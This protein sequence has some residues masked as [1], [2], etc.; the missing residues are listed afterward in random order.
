[1]TRK[2]N[3][4]RTV[5]TL[6]ALALCGLITGA[7]LYAGP[8]TPPVGPVAP[9]LKTL[10]EVEPRIAINATNT[11]GDGDSVFRITSPGSYYLT[12]NLSGTSGKMGIE[13]ASTNV[14]I[15]LSGFSVL[16]GPG[17]LDG[18]A[19][20]ASVGQVVIRNGMITGWGGDGL[21]LSTNSAPGSIVTM[22]TASANA[23]TGIS[24]SAGTMVTHCVAY[25]NTGSGFSLAA[26]SSIANCNA[27]LNSAA[28]LVASNGVNISAF[29]AYQN[30]TV[31]INAGSGSTVIGCTARFNGLDGILAAQATLI[32][33]CVSSSNGFTGD[34]AGIHI[35]GFDCRVEGNTCTFSDRGIDVDSSGNF[36]AR[37]ICSGNGTNWDVAA[38]NICLVV[39]GAPATAIIGNSGGVAPGS[40]DPNANFT[41]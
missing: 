27:Y 35:T 12:A 21:D 38:A 30:T 18:I 14:N 1:M 2:T 28:G 15:D 6:S 23:A 13:I 37:N 4:A 8:L 3:H 5:L 34:G 20:S 29:T 39:S 24:V 41:Y 22:V 40:T 32:K 7:A 16:G 31:G 19:T 36:I 33:D 25:Q 17:T 9:T 11:P 26:G 10:A